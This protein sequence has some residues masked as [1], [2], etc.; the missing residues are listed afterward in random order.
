MTTTRPN[1]RTQNSPDA[2]LGISFEATLPD[3]ND[4]PTVPSEFPICSPVSGASTEYFPRPRCCV[5]CRP[6]ISAVVAMPKTSIY[7]QGDFVFWPDEVRL[8]S[9]FLVSTPTSYLVPSQ[10]TGQFQFG[11]LIISAGDPRH[12]V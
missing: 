1:K 4:D 6:Q 10:K 3:S 7:K 12:Q 9:N 8:T 2:S 11:S 5:S